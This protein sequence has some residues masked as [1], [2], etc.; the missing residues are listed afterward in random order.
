[1]ESLSERMRKYEAV[2]C[3]YLIP[4]LP[5]ILRIDGQNFHMLTQKLQCAKPWDNNI[6]LVMDKTALT[7]CQ[8]IVQNARLAFIQS[9]E[10]NILI[11]NY[12]TLQTQPWF[13]N[14]INKIV[15]TSAAKTSVYFNHFW[16]Q[17]TKDDVNPFATFDCKAFNL[18]KDEVVNYF[19]ER[20]QD[21]TR[22]SIQSYAQANFPHNAL[23]NLNCSQLQNKLFEERGLNWND[24]P[25]YLKR[26][27]CVIKVGFH[28]NRIADL[29]IPGPHPPETKWIVDDNIPIFTENRNY[30]QRLV[31]EEWEYPFFAK[32]TV[33]NALQ[34]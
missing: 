15:S 30:I 13:D 23:Q 4:R 21:A 2:S 9:D 31:A 12:T 3:H 27:R 8:K 18:P 24:L 6:N 1:M 34:L 22:N 10:I 26:G 19:I 20:Q 14:K 5:V 29:N 25:V 28:V 7:L 11:N 33:D 17:N 32:E 16:A